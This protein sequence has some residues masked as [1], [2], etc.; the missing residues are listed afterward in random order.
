LG[1][2]PL[3]LLLVVPHNALAWDFGPWFSGGF[4][5]LHLWG[6]NDNGS[7]VYGN[8]YY[9]GQQDAI[10]DHN[11][12]LVYNPYPQVA[13]QN[14]IGIHSKKVTTSSGTLISRLTNT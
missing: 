4:N 3:I 8:G 7:G 5:G 2:A 12:G 1:T 14:F 9:A 10:Y 13:T 6:S 11:Q